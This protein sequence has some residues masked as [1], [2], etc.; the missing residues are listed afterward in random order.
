MP[1]SAL[2][3]IHMK[4]GVNGSDSLNLAH[5]YDIAYPWLADDPEVVEKALEHLRQAL[6][7]LE[8]DDDA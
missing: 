5:L 6:I 3:T 4:D 2:V 8:I 7:D 1:D